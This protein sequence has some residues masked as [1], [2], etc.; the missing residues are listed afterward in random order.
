MSLH[1]ITAGSGYDYLT[2]QVA[3]HD[4]SEGVGPSLASYYTER[5]EIPGVWVGSGLAGI[6]GIDVGSVVTPD[7]MQSLFGAGRHPN[8]LQIAAALESREDLT[9]AEREAAMN[10]GK[11]FRV[12]EHDVSEFRVEV[13]RAFTT[14]NRSI[15]A[16]SGAPIP[17]DERARI[18]SNIA[19]RF[20]VAEFGREPLDARELSGHL[21][22]LSRQQTTAVAGYDLTFS[23]VKSVSAL[24]AVAPT[25]LAARIEQAHHAAVGDALAFIEREALFTRLGDGGVR[26]VEVKGLVGTAFTHRDSRAGDPDL[27]THV[28]V[29]NKV[30][31][32]DGRWLS[33]DGRVLF[34]ATVTASEVY[35][36]ALER[37]LAESLGVAFAARPGTDPERRP[38]REIQGVPQTLTEAWSRRRQA[39]EDRR[40]ELAA[41]F[42]DRHGRPPTATEQIALAQQATLDTREGKHA[43]RTVAEQRDTWHRQAVSVLGGERALERMLADALRSTSH[44]HPRAARMVRDDAWFEQTAAGIVRTVQ[45][46]RATWQDWHLRAEAYRV[47]RAAEVHSRDLDATVN[48]LVG[49]ALARHSVA[50]AGTGTDGISDPRVLRR[51]DGTTQYSVSRAQLF[52]SSAVLDAEQRM[53]AAAGLTDGRR[54]SD[55]DVDLAFAESLANGIEL[56]LGQQELVRGMATS[57]AR[58]QVAIAPAGSGKT[59][60]MAALARAWAETGGTV[61]GLAPSAA[62]ADQLRG[63]L[64][65]TTDTL[66]KL[67]HHLDRDGRPPREMGTIDANSLVV[68]D[69]AG[70]ADTLT[71]DRAVTWLL[72][73]G[74][75]VRL[76]GDDQQLAAIG[77]GGVLRDIEAQHG[78]LRL[79]DLV[80]FADP[81]E[82]AATLALRDGRDEALGFY[83]DHQRVHVGD[84]ASLT[85][86]VFDAWRIDRSRGLDSIMLAPTRDLVAQLNA[87]A[88]ADRLTT[89]P[90][91]DEAATAARIEVTLSDGNLASAGDTI[92]TR[93]NDR[94]LR[95]SATDWVKNGDRWTITDVTTD[96]LIRAQHLRSGL[97]VTLPADYVTQSVQLGYAST[98][99]TA[100][101]IS[102]DTMHGLASPD[103]ARQPLYT[104]LTRGRQANHLYL[105]VVGDGNEH[106]V[107]HPETINPLAPTDVLEAM[108]TRDD[109]PTSATT[110]QRQAN[111]P[112]RRLAD[113]AHRYTDALGLA[114]ET[115]TGQAGIADLERKC[116]AALPGI[117]YADDW[118]AL[119]T[120]L[121]ILNIAGHEPVTAMVA[122][123]KQAPLS[124]SHD[125]A[126]VLA[127]RLD[128]TLAGG[129][130][131]WLPRI[132]DHLADHPQW[133][134]YLTARA[135][136]TRDL[137]AQ[138]ADAAREAVDRPTWLAGSLAD[139]TPQTLADV[140]VWRAA[141]ALED[142]DLRPTGPRA[143]GQAAQR[144]QQ[145]L[146]DRLGEDRN[147]ALT[148]WAPLLRRVSPMVDRD[149]F[150]PTLAR[151]LAQLN[152]DGHHA[153]Q[154]VDQAAAEGTLP[155]DHAAAA[156]WWRINRLLPTDV[157]RTLDVDNR[158]PAD[159]LVRY[160]QRIDPAI[161]DQLQ[162][163]PSWPAVVHAVEGALQ[164]GWQLDQL[165]TAPPADAHN[166]PAQA[167]AWQILIA[168]APGDHHDAPEDTEPD[169][170]YEIP[171]DLIDGWL[172][173]LD[174]EPAPDDDLHQADAVEADLDLGF[175]AMER[176]VLPAPDP[177]DLLLREQANRA[178]A[179]HDAPAGPERLTAINAMAADY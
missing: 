98:I 156:L 113:V 174:A 94:R 55:T 73:Q 38:I 8:A 19:R 172:P 5:G 76:I 77:A 95:L 69:E 87:R 11:P 108:L 43:P 13:A 131:P 109:T 158:V 53:V 24:W 90:A 29:A 143:V 37:H 35:N 115:L 10:L 141:H 66:A 117:T 136:L 57:G 15:G 81:A 63:Q 111:D 100:Q 3:L 79:R 59:T 129:P 118:I 34:K 102:V 65:S 67:V 171:D 88:R 157:L 18:R 91:G 140:A 175:A 47:A 52:T 122:A 133:G 56:N 42:Q 142:A 146:N 134:P 112:A 148:E 96:G 17:L 23:P 32:H 105:E 51:S 54:A 6:D 45:G 103:L 153:R 139:P 138:V 64:D 78:V 162:S 160:T 176:R 120:Q 86:D 165:P 40:A 170:D 107:I 49:T 1:K 173:P 41:E 74:A 163:S 20:F 84:Q 46:S 21:A 151:L 36:T 61:L 164:A 119:R 27:H 33:I 150:T 155:D 26:Q 126:A 58:V 110:L 178:D 166:D 167:L 72:E 128:N 127:W 22:R 152:A 75:S 144:Y 147:P 159:W 2:R 25:D 28:A 83:F 44:Y 30:Q 132:P 121:L 60:A 39:V 93:T 137:A 14:Y 124:D 82:A 92:I 7:Q 145:A 16:A 169:Y 12:F 168:T 62:A 161:A 31:N 97:H 106:S 4:R 80:R 68:I 123:F 177:S 48:R 130:L 71:L 116:E 101:G 50:V 70:M 179:W 104:M 85:D 89:I 9:P 99:H 149:P 154:L 114:A 135:N 125:P